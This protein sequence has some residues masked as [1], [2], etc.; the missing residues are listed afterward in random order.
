MK[1][2][3]KGRLELTWMGK[4]SALIPVEDGKYD[5]AWVDPSDPRAREVKS[6]EVLEQVGEVDDPAGTDENLLIIG[7]S[8][9]ALRSLGTIPEYRD[10][11]AGQV[12]LV[13][14]DPPFNTEQTFEHYADQLEH[15]VWLTMMRD[16]IR[17]IK[18]LLASDA[19]VWVHLDDAEVHRMRLLLD[20]EFGAENFVAT[21]IWKRRNDPRNT[22]PHISMD[23]DVM[24]VYASDK[25]RCVFNPLVRTAS[26]N[27][28]YVNPDD[29][30]RG[31]WRRS[32]MAARNEYS[33]GL[34]SITTPGGRFI[35]GPPSGSYWR[36]S[37]DE[38]HRLDAD[39]RIYWGPDGKSRPYIK[40][41]LTEVK[42]GRV[43]S[44]VWAPEEVGFV[45]NGKEETRSLVGDVFATPKPERLM[46]RV[47]QI[48]SNPGDLV[49]DCFAGSGTTAAVAHKM[50]RRWV[51]VELSES[52]VNS[53]VLPR[54]RKVVDGADPGG[55]TSITERVAVADL[56][57]GVS[58]EEA[59]KFTTLI[60]KFADQQT[61]PIN[62]IDE[63]AK[64]VR[65]LANGG[66]PRLT[67]EES[68]ALLGLLKKVKLGSD[69]GVTIDVMP[70]AR[71]SLRAA[72]KTRDQSTTVWKG[73]GG[74]TVA[75]VGP[76]MYEVDDEDGSVYLAAEATNGAWSKAVA[77][78]LK[79]TLTPGDPVFCGVRK[80]QRLAVIDGVAD[81]TVVRTVVEHLGEQ[82]KAVIVAKGVLP[83][84][85]ELL[86]SLSPGSRIKK[87]P[88]DIFP[89][90][91]VK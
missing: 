61:L 69:G 70:E 26:M 79:F 90:G 78:Q 15:S 25:Q 47:L 54:L 13:Y 34:Y 12:K 88:G 68:K 42:D 1:R 11:Y 75:K 10:K 29:D 91:T 6:I 53:F 37:E 43:P 14:I 84:A 8:G 81:E 39:R 27:S 67:S 32:D 41:F 30:P 9:D 36:V 72:A 51:T 28:A 18:P 83:E 60:G 5:Y 63:A 46:A 45:R 7:D 31:P 38:M 44:T 80:R 86:Q 71:K 49:L 33:K 21:V 66:E 35:E 85:S 4:D 89:N 82:E 58:P 3:P 16:R 73:G 50:G 74:F 2:T 20:E 65:Q 40:R 23:H 77:G 62:I 87:A 64:A 55:V 19:S 22:A 57:D 48:A 24:L 52:N 56:P 59:Q 17:E 76:S